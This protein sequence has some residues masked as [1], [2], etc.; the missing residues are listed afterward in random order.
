MGEV[1]Q[2]LCFAK[3]QYIFHKGDEGA[4][5]F[6]I[7]SGRVELFD[8]VDGKKRV[9]DVVKQGCLFGEMAILNSRIR[10]LTARALEDTQCVIVEEQKVLSEIQA[11]PPYIRALLRV[12]VKT[13]QK[14]QEKTLEK[15]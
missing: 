3:D 12:L 8:T 10:L 13:V 15:V 6:F 2:R 5:A 7:Q 9:I 14:L 4:H 11:T 1:K